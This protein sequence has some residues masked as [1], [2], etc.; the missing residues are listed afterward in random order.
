[1]NMISNECKRMSFEV[2]DCWK[3]WLRM[4][5]GWRELEVIREMDL[6][7]YSHWLSRGLSIPVYF[8]TQMSR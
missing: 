5:D 2:S 4:A 7:S 1:M 6:V 3:C 8:T